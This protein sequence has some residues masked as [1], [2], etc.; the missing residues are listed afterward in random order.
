MSCSHIHTI[1]KERKGGEKKEKTTATGTSYFG[2]IGIAE[3]VSRFL[4]L[5]S[6]RKNF[7]SPS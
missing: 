2:L 1:H 3:K 4:I 5:I 6:R 7:N